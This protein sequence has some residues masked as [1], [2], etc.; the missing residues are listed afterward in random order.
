M[1]QLLKSPTQYYEPRPAQVTYQ[2][3]R[4]SLFLR[5][6]TGSETVFKK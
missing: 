5:L 2:L 3:L 1:E 4:S 6:K